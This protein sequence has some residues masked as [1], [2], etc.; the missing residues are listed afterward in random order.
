MGDTYNVSIG[1]GDLQ[2]TPLELISAISAISNHGRAFKPH[3]LKDLEPELL[4]DIVDMEP[5]LKE[6]RLG[7]EDGVNK[8]YGTSHILST[9]PLRT[10]AKTGSAQIALNTKTNALFVGYAPTDNPSLAILVL[11]E[12]AREGSMNTIPIAKDVFQWYY[13]NRL[14]R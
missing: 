6:V 10:A 12:D 13:E 3:L 5:A 8:S 1:Q 11:V 7:M 4:I 14:R 2:I 9:L